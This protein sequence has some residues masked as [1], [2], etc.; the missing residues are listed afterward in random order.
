MAI[1][2]CL[3]TGSDFGRRGD[4]LSPH[5]ERM[6]HYISYSRYSL[7]SL[8]GLDRFGDV[9][10]TLEADVKPCDF[11]DLCYVVVA[12][13]KLDLPKSRSQLLLEVKQVFHGR[14]V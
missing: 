14:T 13:G 3:E 10:E 7:L 12:L 8:Y 5:L 9:V 4:C 1:S 2:T 11:H 6:E